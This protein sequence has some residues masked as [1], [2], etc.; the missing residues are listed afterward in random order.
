MEAL[1]LVQPK[2]SLALGITL[3]VEALLAHVKS[4]VMHGSWQFVVQF[5]QMNL[6]IVIHNL[7]LMENTI[8]VAF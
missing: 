2:G 6:S 3:G 4:N 1:Y 5:L 7:S 8:H